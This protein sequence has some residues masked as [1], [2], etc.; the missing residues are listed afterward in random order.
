MLDNTF[1][2]ALATMA[3][4][5]HVYFVFLTMGLHSTAVKM[6][7]FRSQKDQLI[8]ELAESKLISDEARRRAEGANKAKS[9]F[10]ATMSHELRTPLNAIMGF[11]EVMKTELMG[12]L[13]NPTYKDYAGS[14]HD[15]G[16]HLLHLINY[17]IG[18]LGIAMPMTWA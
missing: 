11:S 17:P 9:R 16:K 2:Y 3:V 13:N 4:G 14:I 1:Y 5:V 6:L 10:L 18:D 7:E 8:A 15:S 12:P